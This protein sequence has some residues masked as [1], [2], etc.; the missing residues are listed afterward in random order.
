MIHSTKLSSIPNETLLLSKAGVG[1]GESNS[2]SRVNVVRPL[3]TANETKST[4][5]STL[6]DLINKLAQR[7]QTG[8]SLETLM[9]TGRG[10]FLHKTY[11]GEVS[12]TDSVATDQ[13]LMQVAGFLRHELPIRLAH[14]IQDLDNIP[15][16]REMSSVQ[17][18]KDLYIKSLLELTSVDKEVSTMEREEELARLLEGIYERHAGV[19]VEMARGAFELRKATRNR[20][21]NAGGSGYVEFDSMKE[22]HAFLDRFYLSRIGIRVLIGQYL[23]LRQRPVSNYVG[24]ICSQTSPHEIVKAAIEDASF[25]CTRKYGDSPEVIITGRLDQTFPYVPTHLRKYFVL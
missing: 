13:I 19:L 2:N 25:M 21:V 3:T 4:S 5:D 24:I 20:S 7:P 11:K 12:V 14:R 10:E 8:A 23:S 18:V 17:R 15:E 6:T 9:K 22:T 1:I 16:M